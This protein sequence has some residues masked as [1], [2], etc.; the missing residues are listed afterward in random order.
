LKASGGVRQLFT[1]PENILL[2]Q[3]IGCG[4][5]PQSTPAGAA[6]FLTPGGRDESAPVPCRHTSTRRGL[7]V[8]IWC[9]PSTSMIRARQHRLGF[10]SAELSSLAGDGSRCLHFES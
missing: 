7:L 3:Y 5:E 4:D 2:S 8:T 1:Q 10:S 6:R 9:W